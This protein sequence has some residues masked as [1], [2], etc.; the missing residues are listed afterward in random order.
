MRHLGTPWL[1]SD[2][3]ARFHRRH[4]AHRHPD[5]QLEEIFYDLTHKLD[6]DLGGSGSNLRTPAACLGQSR[7]EYACYNTQDACYQLTMDYQDE[8][9]RPA[10]PY[11]FKFKFDG[12]PNGCVAAMA[13]SDFAVVGTW[14]DDIK[15][16][17]EA[18]KAYVAGRI[19][20]QRRCSR[21]S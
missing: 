15:I 5:P 17:Q 18:V 13:R 2:Q 19:R 3:H 8:L 21:R 7:C 20:P 14:K 12:C 11:K 4:R 9:H 16:D 1:R 10:F 6:V